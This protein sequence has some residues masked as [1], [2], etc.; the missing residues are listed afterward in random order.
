MKNKEILIIISALFISLILIYY[1]F[2]FKD[3]CIKSGGK[4]ITSTHNGMACIYD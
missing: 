1:I 3:R 2:N 4:Y